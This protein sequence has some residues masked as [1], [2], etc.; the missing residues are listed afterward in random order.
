MEP[1]RESWGGFWSGM[2]SRFGVIV[3][4][5]GQDLILIDQLSMLTFTVQ[6]AL[7]SL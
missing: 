7:D 2:K 5:R 1:W 4:H 6:F 3:A